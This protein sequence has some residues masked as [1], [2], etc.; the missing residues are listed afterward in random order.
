MRR[1]FLFWLFFC[2]ATTFIAAFVFLFFIQTRQAD[3]NAVDLIGLKLKDAKEQ[4][5]TNER[6][7]DTIRQIVRDTAMSKSHS[8]AELVLRDETILADPARFEKLAE[9]LDV[10]ELH[11][12]NADGILI[13]S[14]PSEYL[15]YDMHA[16]A[17]SSA[18]IPA[19]TDPAF[20]LL[21]EPR[22][23][24]IDN[25]LFQYAGVARLDEPGIVQ[26][27]FFP[28][29]L[30]RAMELA[31][32][33]N[34]AAGFRIG[35]QG[36]ILVCKDGVIV[37]DSDEWVGKTLADR[38]ID[39]GKVVG[40]SGRFRAKIFDSPN[41][42]GARSDRKAANML[43]L[44]ENFDGYVL[45]GLLP[46]NEMY[47][48]RD[49]SLI[50]LIGFN[51][52]LFGIVCSIV[53]LLVERIVIRGIHRV[54]ASLTKITDGDLDEKVDVRTN[55]EFVSL[56]DGINT[57]VAALKDAIAETAARIDKELE[58]ARVIQLAT[59]PTLFP[60][61]PD[62]NEFDVYATMDT[63]KEVGG[64]FYDFILIDERHLGF[65]IADVSG[66]GIPAAMF[67]MTT[68][69]VTKNFALQGYSPA[70]VL[71]RAN[72]QLCENNESGMFVTAFLG[73]LEIDTGR[74]TCSSAGHNPP[75]FLHA[76]GRTEYLH[77][78]GGIV[79]GGM[80]GVSYEESVWTLEAGD[81]LFLYT[82]GVTEAFDANGDLF[83]EK[84]LLSIL[85]PDKVAGVSLAELLAYVRENVARH[86][87]GA[88]Q[89][90]D[91]TMMVLEYGKKR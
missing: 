17:Q 42:S 22:P 91:I 46:E 79:L 23:K 60:A 77:S 73:I 62:R 40:S 81:R 82:D 84:R 90:D 74:L 76:D 30:E 7:L 5:Q 63:A 37:S 8:F 87:V 12:S 85:S 58:F 54:N 75:V 31:D 71:T 44:Y 68:K 52:L 14:L 18:F 55:A 32:V 3:R 72:N 35:S 56:S 25:K 61:F 36:A 49:R 45:L 11:V 67:M 64:D 41:A 51:V 34:L 15:G 59:L 20:E 86:A 19:I 27:G 53:S 4:I 48:S 43:C 65:I 69:T 83:G 29:R 26:I 89:S 39:A 47:I 9:T 78:A 80:S 13:A 10:D 1:T 2:M 38:G 70:E 6:N 33:R 16:S 66:K 28:S 21:Q 24:G 50:E 57:T 88:V